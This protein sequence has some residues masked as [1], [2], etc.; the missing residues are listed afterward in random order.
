P[1]I[2]LGNIFNN[3]YQ[4]TA[5]QDVVQRY[6]AS[7]SLKETNKSLWT[8]GGIS[9]KMKYGTTDDVLKPFGKTA[10]CV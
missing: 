6:Q 8:N 1:I 10:S 2:F 9:V 5:S 7:D 3:L 4:Y